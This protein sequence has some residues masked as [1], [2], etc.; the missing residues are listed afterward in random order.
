MQSKLQLTTREHLRQT[1]AF[2]VPGRGHNRRK[3]RGLRHY[4]ISSCS[5]EAKALGVTVG[6][7]YE[8][9]KSLVPEMRILPI[10]RRNVRA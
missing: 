2:A 4:V 9:A 6:M 10:G 1:W 8:D 7:H 3:L 5:K